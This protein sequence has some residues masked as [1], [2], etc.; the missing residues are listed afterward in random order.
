MKLEI[1]NIFYISFF[2][3]ILTVN[4]SISAHAGRST[5]SEKEDDET[6]IADMTDIL[7]N[8]QK[9]MEQMPCLHSTLCTKR[10]SELLNDKVALTN[11]TKSEKFSY[12][13]AMTFFTWFSFQL[14]S[15]K[16]THRL[17]TI[18]KKIEWNILLIRRIWN[19]LLYLRNFSYGCRLT[20]LKQN[21]Y[22][23]PHTKKSTSKNWILICYG[24]IIYNATRFFPLNTCCYR[25]F[26]AFNLHYTFIKRIASNHVLHAGC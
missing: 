26:I 13:D 10:P 25:V 19:L 1:L 17:Q 9:N 21:K 5:P 3:E 24:Y 7:L 11:W 14:Q 23:L 2:L 18:E 22:M 15:V 8:I 12:F 20:A 16:W 4:D 6:R